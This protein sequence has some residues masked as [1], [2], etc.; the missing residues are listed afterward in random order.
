MAFRR[1]R[2]AGYDQ[3]RFELRPG[4]DEVYVSIRTPGSEHLRLTDVPL[5][6]AIVTATRLAHRSA[7]DVAVIDRYGL[8][9]D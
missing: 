3:I 5:K 4:A 7:C 2:R 8:W 6:A 9:P 1:Q